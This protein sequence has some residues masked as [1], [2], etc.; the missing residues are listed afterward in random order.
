MS[1]FEAVVLLTDAVNVAALPRITVD[2]E[3]LALLE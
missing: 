2:A 3:L 1:A